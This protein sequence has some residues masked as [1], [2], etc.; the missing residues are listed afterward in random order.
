MASVTGTPVFTCAGTGYELLATG[1]WTGY[2]ESNEDLKI[3]VQAAAGAAPASNTN[4]FFF[5]R[6]YQ[7]FG[8]VNFPAGYKAWVL[9]SAGAIVR[10]AN[11]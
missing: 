6:G 3:V 8:P 10:R 4:D 7:R 1:A 5:V 2:L 9:G 11:S